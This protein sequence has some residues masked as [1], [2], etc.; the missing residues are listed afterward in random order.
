M[1]RPGFLDSRLRGN[2]VCARRFPSAAASPSGVISNPLSVSRPIVSRVGHP[3][4]RTAY[5]SLLC[6][7]RASV[8]NAFLR[9]DIFS[10]AKKCPL[11][12]GRALC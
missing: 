4:R 2:D 3:I 5:L 9:N 1:A 12:F 6:A 7:L 10:R 8:M 11:V